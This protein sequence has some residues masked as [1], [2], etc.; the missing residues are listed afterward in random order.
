M[1][2]FVLVKSKLVVNLTSKKMKKY[3]A[4]PLVRSLLSKFACYEME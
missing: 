3:H 4:K 1:I 2:V